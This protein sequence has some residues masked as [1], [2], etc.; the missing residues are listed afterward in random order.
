MLEAGKYYT[1]PIVKIK[2][3][4]A[5]LGAAGTEI[6]LPKRYLPK[7]LKPGDSLSV[8][9][10]HDS[11]D[12]LIATTEKPKLTVGEIELLEVVS[13]TKQGAFLD[14][15]LPKDLFLPL[16][17]QVS[18]IHVGG[19]YLIMAYI[20]QQTGRVAAT[21]R[22]ERYLQN[23]T[24]TVAEND[25]VTLRIWRKTDIG[26]T[27]IINN[28][29][30]GVL[31]F[32]D[33]FQEVSYGDTLEGFIKKI[34][35]DQKIDVKAGV[36]GYT[37]VQGEREKILQMLRENNGYLPYHDK[38]DPKEIYAAFGISKKTFKMTIGALYKE[39]LIDFAREG[40]ILL[41]N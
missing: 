41:D 10:Y 39:R 32:D 34:R 19:F 21:E 13:I 18:R 31:H 12:R 38:S 22:L 5:Y 37:R 16:S 27:V 25:A 8:F 7:H 30:I 23:E 6:L 2:D 3:F 15:G 1:L 29:H 28:R 17:Q 9:I 20:D 11:E 4:G 36:R 35:E 40:I 33:V 24:L 26:Y 14:W